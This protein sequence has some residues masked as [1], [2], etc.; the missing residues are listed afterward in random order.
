MTLALS[1]TVLF[2]CKYTINTKEKLL[3]HKKSTWLVSILVIA[4]QIQK[5][6]QKYFCCVYDEIYPE[7]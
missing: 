1:L 5:R 6:E 3:S 2:S 7:E 4:V